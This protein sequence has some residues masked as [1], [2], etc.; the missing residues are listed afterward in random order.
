MV[1]SSVA[2]GVGGPSGT[3]T[4]DRSGQCVAQCTHWPS[5]SSQ[6]PVW[7]NDVHVRHSTRLSVAKMRAPSVLLL[8]NLHSAPL[9]QNRTAV[10]HVTQL[11]TWLSRNRDV[12]RRC[13]SS[14]D[15]PD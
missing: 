3:V 12:D 10:R 2:A 5:A 15:C 8:V 9:P 7:Q 4:V 11:F 1:Q 13:P 14:S 6:Q